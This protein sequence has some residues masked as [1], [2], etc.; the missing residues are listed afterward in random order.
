M[1]KGSQWILASVLSSK[2]DNPKRLVSIPSALRSVLVLSLRT[3]LSFTLRIGWKIQR[4]KNIRGK[5]IQGENFLKVTQED[6]YVSGC[7][8]LSMNVCGI[9]GLGRYFVL[10][11]LETGSYS[12]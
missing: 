5:L 8:S 11:C 9:C 2:F 4:R 10:F 12:V 1:P 7:D 3:E 6:M